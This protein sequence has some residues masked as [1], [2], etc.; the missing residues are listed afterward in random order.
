M[1]AGRLLGR[2]VIAALDRTL[3]EL[4]V[5]SLAEEFSYAVARSFPAANYE[6]RFV[7]IA[8]WNVAG[9]YRSAAP[10]AAA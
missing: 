4:A 9:D 2:W 3:P 7:G 8:S 5:Q 6:V 10:Q 1:S